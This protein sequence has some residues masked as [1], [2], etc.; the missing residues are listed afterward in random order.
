M[1]ACCEAET[2]CSEALSACCEAETM[3]SEALSACCEAETIVKRYSLGVKQKILGVT[4]IS[5]E[6]FYF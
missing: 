4:C 2:M 6:I 1:S 5:T 3:Y